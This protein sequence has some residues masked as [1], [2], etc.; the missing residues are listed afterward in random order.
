MTVK[1]WPSPNLS[2]RQI[3]ILHLMAEGYASRVIGEK[4]GISRYTVRN[5]KHEMYKR[6]GASSAEHAVAIAM[7][8]GYIDGD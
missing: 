2:S 6:L 5:H 1:P 8:R 4:L 3:E 7:R